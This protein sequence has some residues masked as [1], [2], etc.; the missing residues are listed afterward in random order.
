[1]CSWPSPLFWAHSKFVDLSLS[2]NVWISRRPKGTIGVDKLVAT[3]LSEQNGYGHRC[4]KTAHKKSS[5]SRYWGALG[6]P[7]FPFFHSV[8][9]FFLF[10]Y[11]YGYTST[12]ISSLS[13]LADNGS[14][15]SMI[16]CSHLMSTALHSPVVCSWVLE[17]IGSR[18]SESGMHKAKLSPTILALQKIWEVWLEHISSRDLEGQRA[19]DSRWKDFSCMEV[20]TRPRYSRIQLVFSTSS[21]GR[22]RFRHLCAPC[23]VEPTS[24]KKIAATSQG[25]LLCWDCCSFRWVVRPG[26]WRAL[27][28]W[29][30]PSVVHMGGGCTNQGVA[31]AVVHGQ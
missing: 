5:W 2:V 1:M 30:V 7:S 21:E 23:L 31:S 4:P 11:W 28:A 29:T 18:S 13:A 8:F 14:V 22:S 6:D 26:P 24:P 19:R 27:E 12:S 17:F 16:C 10:L 9:P 20:Q 3:P 25:M 15:S